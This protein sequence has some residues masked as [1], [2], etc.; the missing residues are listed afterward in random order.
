MFPYPQ[1]FVRLDTTRSTRFGGPTWIHADEVRP[2]T[3]TLVFEHPQESSPSGSG[4]VP[5]VAGK[6][7]EAF[8]VQVLDRHEVVCCGVVI[9][10]LVEEVATCS[11]EF[12]MPLC[13]EPKLFLPVRRSMLLPS[14]LVSCLV[15]RSIPTHRS[16]FSGFSGELSGSSS[17]RV[18]YHFPVGSCF[19]VTV[20][21]TASSEGSLWKVMGMSPSFESHSRAWPLVFLSSK[22]D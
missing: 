18:A 22:P 9:R 13:D 3:L 4:S 1:R 15:P 5:R 6:L 20:L 14:E 19:T 12:T 10:E 11:R 8:D 7:N 17:A 16:G 2:F 21:I